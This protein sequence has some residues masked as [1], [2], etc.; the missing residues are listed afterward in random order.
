VAAGPYTTST[1]F[2]E[3]L[4]EAGV[5]YIFANLGSDHPGL[6]EAFALP[7]VLKDALA[8]VHGGRSTVVSV[9]LPPV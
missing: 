4:A 6:I 3:A 9:H 7:Q 1:A 8:V 5:S 2:L